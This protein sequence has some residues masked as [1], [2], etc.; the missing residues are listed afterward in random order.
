MLRASCNK[1][2]LSVRYV[3]SNVKNCVYRWS[4]FRQALC[5]EVR[6]TLLVHSESSVKLDLSKL[7]FSEPIFIRVTTSNLPMVNLEVLPVLVVKF[8]SYLRFSGIGYFPGR[9]RVRVR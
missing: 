2:K 1:I 7:W 3:A 4:T 5:Y 9:D 8:L 6:V